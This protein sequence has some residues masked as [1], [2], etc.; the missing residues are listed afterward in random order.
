[1]LFPSKCFYKSLKIKHIL[2]LFEL[3][4]ILKNKKIAV[5]NRK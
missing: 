5:R 1:M 4:K 2:Q 3:T